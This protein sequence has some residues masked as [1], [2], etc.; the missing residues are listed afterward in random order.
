MFI[1]L[2][3]RIET[4]GPVLFS[5]VRLG[6]NGKPFRL[7]K[8]RKF[9]HQV[10]LAGR[11]VTLRDDSR[12]THVGRILERM[13]FDEI[14]QLW[15]VLRSDMSIVGPRPETLDFADCF[16][17]IYLEVLDYKPGLFG[18]SQTI[19]RNECLLF[20]ENCDPHVFYRKTLFPLKARLDLTYYPKRNFIGDIVWMFRSIGAVLGTSTIAADKLG[21]I[22]AVENWIRQNIDYD[23]TTRPRQPQRRGGNLAGT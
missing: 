7:Y 5:Q 9:H 1:A 10:K 14:P 19:F 22:A 21:G 18:P 3:I 20:P 17:E 4:P 2:A 23:T 6:Q 11:A 12:F 8:F 15:N 16:V 13:K